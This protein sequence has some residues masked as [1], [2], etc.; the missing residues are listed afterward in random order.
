MKKIFA[1]IS[2]LALAAFAQGE[3][4]TSA[5]EASADSNQTAVAEQAS[6][7]GDDPLPAPKRPSYNF[8]S[9]GLGMSI[10]YNWRDKDY[11][12]KRD[13]DKGVFLHYGRIWEMTTHGAIT[14]MNN[15]NTSFNKD[16]Q[17]QEV[18]KIG[19]RYFFADQVFSPFLGAGVG[20]GLDV[21]THYDHFDEVF[22]IGFAGGLEAG[23]VIFRTST[24]QLEIGTT[25]DLMLDGFNTRRKFGAFSF[26]AAINY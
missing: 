10:W 4:S 17:M 7:Q 1:F 2:I 19:G 26:Y 21:D 13:W 5:P 16:W 3:P 24:T 22:A 9:F 20:V 12:P 8:N 18:A 11:N 25:Y 23:L 14:F 15:F 6:S